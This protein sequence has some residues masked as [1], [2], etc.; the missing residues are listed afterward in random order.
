MFS[1]AKPVNDQKTLTMMQS[2]RV[3]ARMLGDEELLTLTD[4]IAKVT[5][6]APRRAERIGKPNLFLRFVLFS[7]SIG[8]VAVIIYGASQVHFNFQVATWNDAI[9]MMADTVTCLLFLPLLLSIFLFEGRLKR[10]TALR[11]LDRL[12]GLNDAV[13]EAQFDKNWYK[14]GDTEPDNEKLAEYLDC[15][16]ALLFMIRKAAHAYAIN[17]QDRSIIERVGAVR[18]GASDNHT[19]LMMKLQMLQKSN[20]KSA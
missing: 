5:F 2:A 6:D 8:G 11:D 15:C 9:Q 13:Y 16:T 19:R 4:T 10:R 3:R 17:T 1:K 14:V 12:E 7:M 20:G 18:N